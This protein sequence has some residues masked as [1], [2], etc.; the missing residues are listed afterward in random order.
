VIHRIPNAE[1]RSQ[2]SRHFL[3]G[4]DFADGHGLDLVNAR[5]AANGEAA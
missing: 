3:S 2:A 4:P 5:I 1:Q